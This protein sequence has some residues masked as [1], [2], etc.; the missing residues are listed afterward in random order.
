MVKTKIKVK[1]RANNGIAA[2]AALM[3]KTA[4]KPKQKQRKKGRITGASMGPVASINTAPVAIGNSI[5]GSR[6]MSRNIPN[7]V[8]V[9][10]RDFMFTPIG[11]GGITTWTMC[12]GTPLTPVA[13]GDSSIR[14][15]MQ[16]Y[17]KY[18][19]KSCVVHY[20]TSS[21]TSAN[22]DVMF[23]RN[24]NRNSVF[25][26][27]T[28]SFLL[29]FVISDP[30]TVIGPQ[31]TNHSAALTVQGTWKSTDYGMNSDVDDY[32]DGDVF[33][34]SKTSTT[35][36]PGYV[37]FDYV[38]EFAELQIS[39]RLL[40]LPLPRAQW[41][42]TSIGVTA[43]TIAA[44]APVALVLTSNNISG[45]GATNP[46]GLTNGDI[47]KVIVDFT[48]SSSLPS[49]VATVKTAINSGTIQS[50]TTVLQDGTTVYAIVAT[51][52]FNLFPNAE[53]AFTGI[54]NLLYTNTNAT[55]TFNIQVWM[56]LIG[57]VSNTN[58]NP[59]F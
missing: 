43:T 38:I 40:A 10:G 42:Q 5:R 44:N 17:Q 6:S 47:Y 35:D 4:I 25:L 13:F 15:Y 46:P 31:W 30:D 51:N 23:Y 3:K 8:M 58:L 20:V 59:N 37:L 26:N 32:A 50:G 28:S 33:L 55:V 12:G 11:T 27:Q 16:M 41:F 2:L 29:P 49:G 34:L 7:G 14:Q 9:S 54:D 36:S 39:P 1:K 57:T 21:P 22:G 45:S 53:S 56:S 48:N 18:R 52:G 24:K 19:W